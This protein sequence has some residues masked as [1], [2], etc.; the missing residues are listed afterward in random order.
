MSLLIAILVIGLII[1]LHEFGH[2]ITAKI[3]KMPVVDF[4][5][6]MGPEVFSVETQ[7]TTYSIRAFP[8]GGHVNIDGMEIDKEVENGFNSKPA[9]QRF[10]VIIAGIVMNFLTAIVILFATFKIYGT[11]ENNQMAMIGDVAKNSP[12]ISILQKGDLIKEIDGIK[13]ENWNEIA[14]KLNKKFESN[15]VDLIIDRNGTEKE[16]KANLIYDEETNRS[17]LGIQSSIIKRELGIFESLQKSL[18]SFFSIFKDIFVGLGQLFT[19]KISKDDISGPIGVIKIIGNSAQMGV[20]NLAFMIAILSINIGC[21]NLVPIPALDGGRIL[22]I[23]LEMLGIKVN[24]RTEEN[25]HRV[26]MLA[27]MVLII[28]VSFNDILK[29]F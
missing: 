10:I 11:Y 27:L 26:G 2:F 16:L 21:L 8:V 18:E 9:W 1:F 22:F 15:K 17:F 20:V 14:E 4:S 24:K 19:G 5:I 29:I 12:N 25:I 7:E 13:I 6:G 3:F 28:A 23:I